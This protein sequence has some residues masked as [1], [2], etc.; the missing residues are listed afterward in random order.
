M[1]D[2]FDDNHPAV[3][4]LHDLETTAYYVD[5]NSSGYIIRLARTIVKAI[6]E[7]ADSLLLVGAPYVLWF[8]F[9]DNFLV[10]V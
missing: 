8:Q 3:E 7:W 2:K 4:F 10:C 9:S 1:F 5:E 6:L